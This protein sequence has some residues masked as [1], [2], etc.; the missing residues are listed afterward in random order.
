MSKISDYHMTIF[1]TS[2]PFDPRPDPFSTPSG[3]L[4]PFRLP[5]HIPGA[6]PETLALEIEAF[7]DA[8]SAGSPP[9]FEVTPL[10]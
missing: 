6:T 1:M 7:Q 3:G 9:V 4:D 2:Q 10:F 5:P 8:L